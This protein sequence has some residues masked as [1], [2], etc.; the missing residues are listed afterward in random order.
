MGLNGTHRNVNGEM[1]NADPNATRSF[2]RYHSSALPRF[3]SAISALSQ[4]YLSVISALSDTVSY[5]FSLVLVLSST[6]SL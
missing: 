3:V 1:L 4:R 2:Q 5:W 6:G